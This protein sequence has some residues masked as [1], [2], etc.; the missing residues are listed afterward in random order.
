M[1]GAIPAQMGA[2]VVE[3]PR[4]AVIQQVPTPRAGDDEVLIRVEG[5]G[6]CGSSLPVWEGRPWFQYPLPPGNPGH[7]GWGRVVQIG[8]RV[9]AV[10]VGDRVS[11]LSDRAFAEYATAGEAALCQVPDELAA[12]PFPGEAFG[13]VMNIFRRSEIRPGQHVAIV[14][15]GFL[16]AGLVSLAAK[17]GAHV[18][19]ISRRPWVLELARSLGAEHGVAIGDDD[20]AVVRAVT[21]ISGGDGCERV[22]EAV[23]LQR[24]LTLATQLV[25]TRG[26]LIIAG[27]HQDGPRQVDMFRWNWRG[28]DVINAHERE[29]ARYV[30]GMRA[31]TDAVRR[32]ALDVRRL[33]SHRFAFAKAGEAFDAMEQRPD[34]F[35]KAVLTP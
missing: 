33:V 26:R 20:E 10:D 28:L 16:G 31:A 9:G 21:A 6:V 1:S 30:D 7:E 3:G 2:V 18:I 8:R 24:A 11:F 4:R 19:A 17:A 23:G 22:I 15:T 35:L 34:G 5:C 27:F 14:G 12:M 25:A 29:P 32:G 13:C